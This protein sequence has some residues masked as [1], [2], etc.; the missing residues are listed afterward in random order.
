MIRMLKKI[1]SKYKN[2]FFLLG[3]KKL[4]VEKEIEMTIKKSKSE[5]SF[6]SLSSNTIKIFDHCGE[7]VF[8]RECRKHEPL[9]VYLQKKIEDFYYV[10][11]QGSEKVNFLQNIPIEIKYSH[12]EVNLFREY[13]ERCSV[14]NAFFEKL[15]RLNFFLKECNFNIWN[16]NKIV[17]PKV[18]DSL[19]FLELP[20]EMAEIFA[21]FITFVKSAIENYN[22]HS[23]VK[24]GQYETFA[25]SRSLATYQLAKF[26]GLER[27]ITPAKFVKLVVDG[28]SFFGVLCSKAP[29]VR[30]FDSDYG[31]T[32][33]F[34]RELTNLKV[35]DALC[36][37]PDHWVNNY[38]VTVDE[39]GNAVSVCAFDNDNNWTFMPF[40]RPSFY[41][42]CSGA[43]LVEKNGLINLSHLDKDVAERI[44]NVNYE[45]LQNTMSRYL[46][47]FQLKALLYR[48]KLLQSSIKKSIKVRPNFLI[49]AKCWSL[50]CA[51]Q[52]LD[53]I[54]GKTSIWQYLNKKQT[55]DENRMGK[56]G[57]VIKLI[58]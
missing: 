28:N 34:H 53:G 47:Y 1:L 32:P 27:L 45:D 8:F 29:G 18:L 15:R 38:N 13:I 7:I 30:A 9:K 58:W 31:I 21:Y 42:Q 36:L 56:C 43:P 40:H 33:S 4:D 24:Y 22:F 6:F 19:G 16:G 2:K 14:D 23:F 52:E 41:S 48:F 25:A 46:N 37:Q 54:F 10:A 11:E 44:L 20:K 50:D 5:I 51:K 26:L 12:D 3:Y 35:L 39:N 55:E 57:S 17:P 49:D